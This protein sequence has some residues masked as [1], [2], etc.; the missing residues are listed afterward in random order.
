[1]IEDD[2]GLIA[3]EMGA[4]T[5]EESSFFSWLTALK[6]ALHKWFIKMTF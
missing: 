1:M 5:D 2:G 4:V 6:P 3:I